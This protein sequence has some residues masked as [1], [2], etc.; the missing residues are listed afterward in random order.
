[1]VVEC[2]KPRAGEIVQVSN[3]DGELATSALAGLQPNS[4]SR[5]WSEGDIVRVANGRAI[6]IDLSG[7]NPDREVIVTEVGSNG[8]ELLLRVAKKSTAKIIFTSKCQVFTI[9]NTDVLPPIEIAKGL[10]LQQVIITPLCDGVNSVIGYE[11]RYGSA[12]AGCRSNARNG[13]RKFK[14]CTERLPPGGGGGGRKPDPCRYF[15]V[16]CD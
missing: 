9:G 10:A 2:Q 7:F 4:D 3:Q 11:I 16:G 14:L 5:L 8:S 6:N 1:M 13:I 15:G 12:E